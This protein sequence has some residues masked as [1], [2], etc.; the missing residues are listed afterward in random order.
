MPDCENS[1][2][3]NDS[4]EAIGGPEPETPGCNITSNLRRAASHVGHQI[5]EGSTDE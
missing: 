2:T 1:E 5:D 3:N 4:N